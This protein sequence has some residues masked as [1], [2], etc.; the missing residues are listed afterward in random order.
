MI[1]SVYS[2]DNLSITNSCYACLIAGEKCAECSDLTDAKLTNV[3]HDFVEENNDQYARPMSKPDA[4]PSGHDWT[5]RPD[6]LKPST[7]FIE[8]CM[9]ENLALGLGDDLEYDKAKET[10]CP[11]CRLIQLRNHNDCF[12]CSRPLE[13]NVR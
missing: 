8:D 10:A 5:D 11:W 3:A 6:E 13:V 9:T 1:E 2:D 4:Q 7:V 12:D